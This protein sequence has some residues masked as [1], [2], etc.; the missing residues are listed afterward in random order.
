MTAKAVPRG[1]SYAKGKKEEENEGLY[2]AGG[3]VVGL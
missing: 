3:L 1:K 2:E